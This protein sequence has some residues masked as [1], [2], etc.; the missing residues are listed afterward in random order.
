MYFYQSSDSGAW[1][2][3]NTLD[4]SS[5][6]AHCFQDDIED[7]SNNV[8]VSGTLDSYSMIFDCGGSSFTGEDTACLGSRGY[9]EEVCVFHNNPNNTLWTGYSPFTLYDL[10]VNDQPV[11]T[12]STFDKTA[13][14]SVTWYL[15]FDEYYKYSDDNETSPR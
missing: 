15:H 1:V 7:C 12:Y 6:F 10:C 5:G 4:S 9:N 11:Y 8:Y 13:N 14:M 3:S 2:I